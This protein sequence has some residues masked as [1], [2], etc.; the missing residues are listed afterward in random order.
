MRRSHGCNLFL[1]LESIEG[2]DRLSAWCLS[3]SAIDRVTHPLETDAKTTSQLPLHHNLIFRYTE[4]FSLAFLQ[5]RRL[6]SDS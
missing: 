6:W 3:R 1:I 5:P 2:S 4:I